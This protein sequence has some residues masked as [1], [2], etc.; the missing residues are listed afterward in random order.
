MK[1]FENTQIRTWHIL[2]MIF[3]F[4][5]ITY[6]LGLNNLKN[7]SINNIEEYLVELNE[8]TFLDSISSTLCF[9]LY[10]AEDS[11]PCNTMLCNL[12]N[13][14]K[15]YQGKIGFYKLN[16]E[17][18][19]DYN[20]MYNVSGVPNIFIFNKGEEIGRIMGIVSEHNLKRIFNKT[21]LKNEADS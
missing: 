8:N 3:I 9:V 6:L 18:C 5:V 19:L 21:I 13:L 11:K 2:I 1:S 12:N 17:K 10:Y 14:A 4:T 20:F 15:E 16:I 7:T